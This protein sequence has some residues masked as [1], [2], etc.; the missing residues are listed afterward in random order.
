MKANLLSYTVDVS[1]MCIYMIAYAFTHIYNTFQ[2]KVIRYSI[3]LKKWTN[4]SHA[5]KM[6]TNVKSHDILCKKLTLVKF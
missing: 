6:S 2:S 3:Y 1:A 4:T 5:R